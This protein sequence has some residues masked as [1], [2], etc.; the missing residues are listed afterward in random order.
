MK[1]YELTEQHRELERLV[2]EEA[3]TVDQV[4]DTFEALEGEFSEKAKSLICVTQ[5]MAKDIDSIGEEVKRL[6]DRKRALQ[7][8]I[9]SAREYLRFNMEATGINKIECPLFS[10]QLQNGRKSVI[11]DDPLILPLGTFTTEIK[12]DKKAIKV[13]IDQDG[14]CEGAHVEQGE[15]ILVIK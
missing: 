8:K 1:I 5:G 7:N 2:D 13:L 12:P 9:D 15:K 11:V 14:E 10:I 6:N 4:A 3:F